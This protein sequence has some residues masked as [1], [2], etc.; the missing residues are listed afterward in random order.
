M[1][2]NLS[3]GIFL[4]ILQQ[5]SKSYFELREKRIVSWQKWVRMIEEAFSPE[6]R[7]K[8]S[9]ISKFIK[10]SKQNRNLGPIIYIFDG[11]SPS[12]QDI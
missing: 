9:H 12:S 5:K 3:G 6:R 10:C 4:I 11:R 8:Q 1:K 7:P 2:K